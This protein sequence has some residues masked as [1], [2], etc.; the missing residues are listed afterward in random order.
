[1]LRFPRLSFLQKSH[2][3][4]VVG[5]AFLVFIFNGSIPVRAGAVILQTKNLKLQITSEGEVT[6]AWIGENGIARDFTAST[7]IVDC[8]PEGAAQWR[9]LPNGGVEVDRTLVNTSTKASCQIIDRFLPL[10]DSIRW[11]V[12]IRGR[13]K[14]WGSLLQTRLHYP[15]LGDTRFWTS[16]AQPQYESTTLSPSL[17]AQVSSPPGDP[18]SWKDPLVPLPFAKALLYYGAPFL[19]DQNPGIPFEPVGGNLFSIPL[20]SMLE[21]GPD[22]GLSCALSPEDEIIDMTLET[23]PN[24]DT[25]F[26]RL[27]NRISPAHPVRFSLNLIAHQADWRPA[28]GWMSERYPGYFR[29]KNSNAAELDGTDAYSNRYSGFDVEKMKA[30]AF[31]TNWQASFDF[32]YMGMFLPPVGPREQWPSYGGQ[33]ISISQMEREAAGM[34]AADFHLLNYFNVTEFGTEVVF[35][36]P[37]RTETNPAD[38]WKN[39]NDFLSTRLSHA[40]LTVPASMNVQHSY[41]KKTKNGGP[42]YTW[43]DAVVMDCADPDY[44][45]FLLD[46]AH[47]TITEIPSADGICI[48][49]MDWL[50]LFNEEADDGIS[51]HD[52]KPVRSLVTSW[53][54]LMAKLGPL[55]HDSNKSILVNNHTKRLDLLEQADGIL[56]EFGN[57][58]SSI[59]LTALLCIQKP[60]LGWT[61]SGD[62]LKDA[63]SFFQ[64]YLYMGM[65]PMCPFPNNDHSIQPGPEA[66]RAYLDYGP[67]MNLLKGRE[68]VLVSHAVLVQNEAAKANLFQTPEG[69]VAPVVYGHADTVTLVVAEAA[70]PQKDL[71]CIVH[72]PG[73]NQTQS[74]TAHR[75]AKNELVLDVPLE[76]HCALVTMNELKASV[77]QGNNGTIVLD[78]AHAQIEGSILVQCTPPE[79][80]SWMN[81]QDYP[82]WPVQVNRPGKFQVTL[83]YALQP[84]PPA[85]T[86]TLKVGNQTLNISPPATA[87]WGDYK[88]IDAGT[89][90]VSAPGV[91]D[92]ILTGKKGGA[93]GVINL[94]NAI[95]TPVP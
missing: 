27:F 36:A 89:I 61:S 4:L 52:Q 33:R 50:R 20:V 64:K 12:E 37:S 8:E 67:L 31:A 34:K 42:F 38:L 83:E 17:A 84:A 88:K 77:F 80:D 9:M 65:F 63:D 70:L 66:D 14:T 32:P 69:Y 30:M 93:E 55:M 23:G 74:L 95:L 18:A 90:T 1:M 85:P 10:K 58:G 73:T 19:D 16:W 2:G 49:R 47:R 41:Y 44:Q 53:K 7:Q 21:P 56:D 57:T 22:I 78:A 40:V 45:N 24:G 5:A 25:I 91:Q 15:V 29:P 75:D 13:D 43:G 87:G 26:S 72:Y 62:E 86:L 11:E 6:K 59:N 28:L 48:D 51:W 35:P 60:A 39:C 54:Q 71:V 76:R 92:F 94:R 46:Q 79:L 81:E 68:W 82:H 3:K